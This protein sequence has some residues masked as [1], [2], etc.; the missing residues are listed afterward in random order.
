MADIMDT[1]AGIMLVAEAMGIMSSKQVLR[2]MLALAF[3]GPLTLG[4]IKRAGLG[5]PNR[6]LRHLKIL[7]AEGYVKRVRRRFTHGPPGR[8]KN[9]TFYHYFCTDEFLPTAV[10]EII[11]M[12][13]RKHETMAEGYA[14]F[15]R[16]LRVDDRLLFPQN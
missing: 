9:K 13:R 11:Q 2:I 14:Q 6:I 1:E 10:L 15:E 16:N 5:R 3:R 7:E 12:L 8:R 4:E